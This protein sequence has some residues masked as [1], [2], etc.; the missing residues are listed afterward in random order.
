MNRIVAAGACVLALSGCSYNKQTAT[1]TPTVIVAKTN[2]GAG[3][4]VGLRVVD[5]RPTK[6]LGHRGNLHGRAAEITTNQDLAAVVHDKISEG[7]SNRGYA[8]VPYDGASTK[9]SIELRSL[10][11]STST[12]FWSGGVAVNASMKAVASKPGDTYEKMYRS[13]AERRVQFVPT[14][15]KNEQDLN[16]GVSAIITDL[17]DDAGLFR[18]IRPGQ[19]VS[20]AVE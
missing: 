18:F 13:D 17:F 9:L 6:S 7:L 16:N 19:S 2:E 20:A 8:V 12:G 10:E 4:P 1:F 3:A 15:G 5:E 11:Y 14:A